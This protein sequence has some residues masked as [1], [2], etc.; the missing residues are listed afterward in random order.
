ML[1]PTRAA[2]LQRLTAFVPRAAKAYRDRRNYD[3]GPDRGTRAVSG[4]SPYLRYRL[5]SESE[6]AQAVLE[7]H[8]PRE[9][10]SFLS[11]VL[12][13]TYWKGWLEGRPQ[14]YQLYRRQLDDD[15]RRFQSTEGY[16]QAVEGRT[17]NAAFDAWNQEL[18]QTGTLHNHARMWYASIWIFTLRL[19]WTLGAAHFAE[20]LIDG[21]PASNTLS[22]R[23][24]AGLQTPGKAY[25]ATAANIERFT[26]GRFQLQGKLRESAPALT[27]PPAPPG[28][29]APLPTQPSERLGS[30]FALL[31]T[32]DD[33]SPET[34]LLGT[35]RPARILLAGLDARDPQEQGSHLVQEFLRGALADAR[36]RLQAHFEVP[37]D[38]LSEQPRSGQALADRLLA[39]EIPHLLYLQ[40]T[41]GPEQELLAD[42]TARDVG[43]KYFPVRRTWDARLF[44]MADKG[45]FPFQKGAYPLLTQNKGQL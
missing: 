28:R 3:P 11:E 25:L 1:A 42:L 8:P 22:W 40:P 32:L 30:R 17:G 21:D 43:L 9:V 23:W 34:T 36:E 38:S 14:V 45:F 16:R 20:H 27:G 19:P 37:V 44:P 39:D 4:L 29:W 2:G 18:L 33:L 10:E 24:V 26:E 7:A 35:L 15:R 41:V 5:L 31:V 6:V 13:R 12:W